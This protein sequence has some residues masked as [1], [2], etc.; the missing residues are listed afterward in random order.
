MQY[1]PRNWTK[2][3]KYVPDRQGKQCRQR[4]FNHLDP[5]INKGEW[6]NDQ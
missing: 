5:N 1:G 4:W 6:S 2:I 3:A